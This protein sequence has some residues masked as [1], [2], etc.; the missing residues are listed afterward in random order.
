MIGSVGGSDLGFHVQGGAYFDA[1]PN[2]SL[3]VHIK[4]LLSKTDVDGMEVNLGGVEYGAGLVFRF[5]L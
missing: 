5:N 1:L 2:L 4:Y 3:K